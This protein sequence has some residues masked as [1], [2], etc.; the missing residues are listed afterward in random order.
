VAQVAFWGGLVAAGLILLLLAAVAVTHTSRNARQSRQARRRTE[1]V[2]LVHELLDADGTGALRADVVAAPAL[3]DDLVL[4]LATQLRGADRAVLQ[5]V[6]TARGVV[7]RAARNLTARAAWRRGRAAVLLGSA[8]SAAHTGALARLLGDR[9]ADVRSAAARAL[10]KAG[11]ESAAGPLLAALTGSAAVPAGIVGM[12]LL[13]LGTPALPA[14]RT[15]LDSAT[16]VVAS[17]AADLLGLHGDAAATPALEAAVSD[18]RAPAD[19]CRSAA[20]AL[21]RIGSPSS[22][23]PLAHVLGGTRAPAVRRSAA[24]AL[25]RIGD[26]DALPALIRGLSDADPDV[27]AACADAM[28]ALGDEGSALLG[29]ITGSEGPAADAARATLDA[30]FLPAAAR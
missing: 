2:P 18:R 24:E 5:R 3:L 7:D 10:G 28:N 8:A 27:R 13:D 9:S 25:G 1:L 19:L 15:A 12:A 11:N 23:G 20:A 30:R 14:L 21:G 29:K 22:T 4:D 6:L 26:P 17:L 16:P